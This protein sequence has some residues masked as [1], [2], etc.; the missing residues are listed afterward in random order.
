MATIELSDDELKTFKDM[1]NL[2]RALM[3]SV[4]G[5]QIAGLS[6]R[7]GEFM[8][9]LE[10]LTSPRV[11]NALSRAGDDLADLIDLII[12]YHRS[13][14]IRKALELITFFSVL[15]EALSTASVARMAESANEFL[16]AGDQL[17]S[18]I[19]CVGG[20]KGLA[21]A[22]KEASLEAE[23]DQGT[24]GVVGLLRVLKEPDVQRATKFFLHFLKAVG[25]AS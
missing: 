16:L 17:L 11:T 19:E 23:Q 3:S 24:I 6:A 1:I 4:S 7:I 25:K 13:G 8:P 15:S 20:V 21:R 5:S 12:R 22:L 9:V 14:T 18:G 2:A 10:V